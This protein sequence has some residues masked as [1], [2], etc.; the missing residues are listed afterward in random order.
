ML[1]RSSKPETATGDPLNDMLRGLRLDGVDYWRCQLSAPWGFSF[2]AQQAARFHFVA[3]QG[4]WLKTP[5]GEWVAL[6]PGDAVLLPRGA[7]HA[8]A[9]APDVPIQPFLGQRCATI[10]ADIFDLKSG[11]DGADSVLFCCSLHFN[12]DGLHP[13]LRMMPDVMRA[14]ELIAREPAVPHLL[15]AMGREVALD[16]VGAAGIAARLADVLAAKIIRF[17]VE[18]GCGDATGW[19]AAVRNPDVGRVL[20]AI[21]LN[22]DRDWTVA[23]LA[24]IMGA[25]RSSFADRFA[26]IVGETPARYVAQVRM[27]QARQWIQRDRARISDVARRLGYDSEAAFSRAF[28]RIIGTAPSHLRGQAG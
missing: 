13:L 4:C 15:E 9:S 26:S 24:G 28:K 20:A 5:E 11:G 19:I 21:H 8:L 7:A 16:R 22:P 18:H 12:L 25:S 3:E 6:T 2:A 27:H 1:S 17:W 14:T 23:A 10:C